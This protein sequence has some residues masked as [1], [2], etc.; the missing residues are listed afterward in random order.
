MITW[1]LGGLYQS[2]NRRLRRHPVRSAY[3]QIDYPVFPASHTLRIE[4]VHL[5]KFAGEVIF[6]NR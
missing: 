6:L 5:F 3:S 1:L 2:V 4:R